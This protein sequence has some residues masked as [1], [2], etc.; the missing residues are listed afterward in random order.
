[1]FTEHPIADTDKM[2]AIKLCTIY[3]NYTNILNNDT[4]ILLTVTSVIGLC[5]VLSPLPSVWHVA[6]CQVKQ[7]IILISAL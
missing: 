4:F 3:I 5:R 6:G 1:M 2:S 7:E